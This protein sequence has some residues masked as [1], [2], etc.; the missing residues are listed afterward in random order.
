M[1]RNTLR[2]HE[3]LASLTDIL[4]KETPD[5]FEA[6]EHVSTM[7][8]AVRPEPWEGEPAS[9][10]ATDHIAIRKLR[11]HLWKWNSLE[12]LS[13]NSVLDGQLRILDLS[14]RLHAHIETLTSE[15]GVTV[16][17][18]EVEDAQAGIRD[19][20]ISKGF[21]LHESQVDRLMSCDLDPGTLE[22]LLPYLCPEPCTDTFGDLQRD[23]VEASFTRNLESLEFEAA[24]DC[25]QEVIENIMEALRF[26][27]T[28][29]RER[30]IL[31][32]D[33][34]TARLTRVSKVLGE[35]EVLLPLHLQRF[36][37]V[38]CSSVAGTVSVASMPAVMPN[39]PLSR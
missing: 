12:A 26:A 21:E 34:K 8:R 13:L 25:R 2:F 38:A 11:K 23:A 18:E 14:A 29:E 27:L 17:A 37:T 4:T 16:P 28:M 22:A 7:L 36:L 15:A 3:S 19:I 30:G 33:E 31:L 10:G 5:L 39:K 9:M 35:R 1:N 6:E 32:G 20:V 24:M